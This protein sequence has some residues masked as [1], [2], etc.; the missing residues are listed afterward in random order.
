M[1]ANFNLCSNS[2]VA[3]MSNV[4]VGTEKQKIELTLPYVALIDFK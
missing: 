3:D 4:E 1:L 2:S